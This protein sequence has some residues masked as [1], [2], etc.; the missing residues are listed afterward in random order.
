MSPKRMDAADTIDVATH[1]LHRLQAEGWTLKGLNHEIAYHQISA[2]T[3]L[4]TEA[5]VTITLVPIK[6]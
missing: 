5:V 1:Y 2:M 3:K 6:E 4:P